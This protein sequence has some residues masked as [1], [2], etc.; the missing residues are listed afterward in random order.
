MAE[1]RTPKTAPAPL[2][3]T[4]DKVKPAPKPRPIGANPGAALAL[5]HRARR[6]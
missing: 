4:G 5:L 6:R 2:S 1:R 3:P